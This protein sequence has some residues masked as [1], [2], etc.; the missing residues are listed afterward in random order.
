MMIGW[1]E[2]EASAAKAQEERVPGE[3]AGQGD[4][5]LET[6]CRQPEPAPTD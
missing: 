1:E 3:L 2:V 5:D 4:E 6:G